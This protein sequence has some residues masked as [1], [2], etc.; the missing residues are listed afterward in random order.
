MMKVYGRWVYNIDF[1]FAK[2][3]DEAREMLYHRM[4]QPQPASMSR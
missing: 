2:N 3:L 4:N 1:L